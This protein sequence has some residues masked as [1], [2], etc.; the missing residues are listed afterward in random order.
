MQNVVSNEDAQEVI[1]TISGASPAQIKAQTFGNWRRKR[2]LHIEIC[3]PSVSF[4][5]VNM[6]SDIA[7]GDFYDCRR[8]FL[9]TAEAKAN[10]C[11][12]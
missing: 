6:A 12:P 5:I 4:F 8:E 1:C 7:C 10:D 11:P 9:N 3:N 2:K